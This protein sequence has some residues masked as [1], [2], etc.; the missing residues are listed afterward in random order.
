MH[1]HKDTKLPYESF[2]NEQ[3]YEDEKMLTRCFYPAY[4]YIIIRTHVQ[5]T[6]L[7]KLIKASI[8]ML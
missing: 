6:A 8:Q 4:E 5:I 7:N 2:K 1:V 3:Y